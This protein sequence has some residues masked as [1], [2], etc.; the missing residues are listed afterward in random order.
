MSLRR[1]G[2][3]SKKIEQLRAFEIEEAR[4]IQQAMVCVEPLKLHP[5]EIVS[6]F[7][8]VAEV[9]GDFLDY[10]RLEDHR[11][12]LY[13]GDVVG[14]G[15]AAAMYAALAM[16][17]LRGIHKRGTAP[18]AVLE[19]MNER[20]RM[21]VVPGRYCAV[22]YAVYDPATR[23]LSYANAALPRP[24]LIS[25]QGCR[26]VGE[27]G[28]PSGL[29]ADAQYEGYSVQLEPGEAVLFCTDG[30]PDARNPQGDDFGLERVLAVCESHVRADA[31]ALLDRLFAE[32]DAFTGDDL[33]HDDMTAIVLKVS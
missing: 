13:L 20:L 8:P 29:F 25:P 9:G 14:K 30:I 11:M 19:L 15:L 27:G 33:P 12:G 16:G 18:T 5:V 7:R 3:N 32:V 26:E 1:N 28:L 10:F 6:R 21:R 4:N 23:Q 24:I 17:T 2:V 31:D 22:Q